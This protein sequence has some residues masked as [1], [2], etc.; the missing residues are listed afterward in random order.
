MI[1]VGLGYTLGSIVWGFVSSRSERRIIKEKRRAFDAA[2]LDSQRATANMPES[3]RRR[4]RD[5][6]L[7]AANAM[8][9]ASAPSL[10]RIHRR[11]KGRPDRLEVRT[12]LVGGLG[13]ALAAAPFTM[14]PWERHAIWALVIVGAWLG[15]MLVGLSALLIALFRLRKI[16][17]A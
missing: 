12:N 14:L 4:A 16:P 8:S 3:D 15:T 7:A 13:F 10:A 1:L 6:L 5:A 17:S 11:L 2:R 9:A